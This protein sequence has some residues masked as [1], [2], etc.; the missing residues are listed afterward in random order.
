MQVLVV[1]IPKWAY[2]VVRYLK[3]GK[4]PKDKKM[5]WQVRMRSSR[6]TMIGNMLYRKGYMLPLLK[7]ISKA[8]ANYVL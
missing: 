3:D 2:E 5:Y 6:Y 8:E 7:C 4:L 1:E